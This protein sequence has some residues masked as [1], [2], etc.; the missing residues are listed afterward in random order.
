MYDVQKISSLV[1]YILYHSCYSYCTL[2]SLKFIVPEA[3]RMVAA[4]LPL[5]NI[6]EIYNL[7]NPQISAPDTRVVGNFVTFTPGITHGDCSQIFLLQR[8]FAAFKVPQRT[9]IERNYFF[10][11]NKHTSIFR[12]IFKLKDNKIVWFQSNKLIYI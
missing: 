11:W 4:L 12:A 1:N 8:R 10:P 9:V 7:Y 6:I 5:W 3:F 2:K